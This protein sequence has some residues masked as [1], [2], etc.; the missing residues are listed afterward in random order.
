MQEALPE[1]FSDRIIRQKEKQFCSLLPVTYH[2]YCS[3]E[4]KIKQKE[5]VF[6]NVFISPIN[7]GSKH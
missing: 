7:S 1:A 3:R 2:Q 4:L 5:I 6:L